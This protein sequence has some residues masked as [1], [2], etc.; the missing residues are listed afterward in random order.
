MPPML[1]LRR[2]V[3]SAVLITACSKSG[4]PTDGAVHVDAAV[5][6]FDGSVETSSGSRDAALIDVALDGAF[7]DGAPMTDINAPDAPQV[8][9]AGWSACGGLGAY[10]LS[11]SRGPT[12]NSFA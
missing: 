9:N 8:A 7:R 12:P 2:V 3:I 6:G 4:A 1:Q 10:P 5:G 11:F